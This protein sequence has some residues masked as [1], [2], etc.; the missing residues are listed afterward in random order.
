MEEKET[1]LEEKE[2]EKLKF[3]NLK[4]L[5]ENFARDDLKVAALWLLVFVAKTDAIQSDK[6]F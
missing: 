4:V 1:Q 3:L 6:D 2:N 5:K